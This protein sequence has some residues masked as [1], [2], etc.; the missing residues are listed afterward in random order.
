MSAINLFPYLVFSIASIFIVKTIELLP[1][2]LS[3]TNVL[4]PKLTH[5]TVIPAALK[6]GA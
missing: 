6:T 5:R 3:V 2:V 4:L 1:V